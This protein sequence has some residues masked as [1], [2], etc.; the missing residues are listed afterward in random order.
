MLRDPGFAE[1]LLSAYVEGE[2]VSSRPLEMVTA[3]GPSHVRARR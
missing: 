1:T 3:A 2:G